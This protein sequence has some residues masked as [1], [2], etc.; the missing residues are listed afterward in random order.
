M[1]GST[2]TW[3]G[4]TIN[5]D[6]PSDWTLTSGPGNATDIPET[7]DTAINNGTLAGY[8]LIAASLINNGTIEAS[9]NSA[10]GSST[11]RDLEIQGSV[12]GTGSLTIASGATLVVDG[13][14]GAA[15]TIAFTPGAPETLILGSPAAIT[16]N[17]IT[18]F[19]LGDGL[20]FSNVATVTAGTVV[21]SGITSIPYVT[22]AGTAGTFQFTNL[23][24]A[25][26]TTLNFRNGFDFASGAEGVT[27]TQFFVWTG[28]AS[29][30]FGTGANWNTGVTPGPLDFADF[31]TSGGTISGSGASYIL[32]FENDGNWALA[33]GTTLSAI[34]NFELGN[35][36]VGSTRLSVGNSTTIYS[37][38]FILVAETAGNEDLLS[39]TGGGVV[40]QT[41]PGVTFAAPMLIG[42][43]GAS[44]TLA[45]ADGMVLVSGTGSLL[46]LGANA[47]SVAG[48]GGTGVLTIQQGERSTQ[49]L[50]MPA[51]K[52]PCRSPIPVAMV[53]F[54]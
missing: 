51:W 24:Y 47:L 13:A 40:R 33:P 38:G 25:A 28:A 46:D 23:N 11:G 3:I 18:G 30:N 49:Q 35:N 34:Q 20:E 19:A 26:G 14:L 54:L 1:S 50:R 36:D 43:A 10:P 21:D 16:T 27:L 12:S 7:G 32:D 2:W 45:P 52:R 6:S 9:I 48:H 44:G 22:A 29:T 8:G 41:A 31:L 4:G 15:Q 17:T 53:R 5:L 37:A 39:I 42:Y